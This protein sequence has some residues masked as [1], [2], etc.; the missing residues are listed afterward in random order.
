MT[1]EIKNNAN[2]AWPKCGSEKVEVIY[3]GNALCLKHWEL[4]CEMTREDIE[5]K[6]DL[7]DD[8]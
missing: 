3:L 7:E 4:V 2:C 8:K 6:L 5:K 1:N